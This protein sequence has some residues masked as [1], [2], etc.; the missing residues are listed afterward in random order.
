MSHSLANPKFRVAI[1]GAG[2]GGLALAVTI[3]KFAGHDIHIDLYEAHDAITTVGAGIVVSSR[4]SEVM[5]ELDMYEEISRV[6]T[7]PPSSTHGPKFRRSNIPQGGFEWFQQT[8]TPT[9]S[10]MHRQHLVDALKQYLPPSCNIHFNKRLTQYNKQL[11]GSLILHFAD[12]STSTTDVLV[13]A[14]GVHSSVRKTLFETL[15]RDVVDPSNI[16]HYTDPS[17]TGTLVYRTVFPAK[18]LS[19]LDPN[20]VALKDF[21]I[22]CGHRKQ[23]VSYPV[24][25]GTLINVVASITDEEKAGTPFEGRWVSSVSHEEVQELYQD[26]EPT[27]KNLLKCFENSSRWALHVVNELPLSVYNRV[28]LIGDACHA[29]T[30]HFGAGAGQAME[31]AFVL[32]RLLAHPLTTLDNVPAALKAYQDVRLP[33]AQFV[34]RESARTGRML[35][36][37]M[38][39]T[40]GRNVREELEIQ[41]EKLLAQWEW[42]GKDSPIAEWLEAERKLQG[43]IGV[44]KGLST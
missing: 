31:D 36:F 16:R 13:G 19:D 34:A 9:T 6:S 18:K 35:S 37:D 38:S 7:K 22:F 11:S 42:E 25:Q 14:D 12:D 4:T 2:I 27:V 15:D 23:V 43:S 26:F 32:G 29:M 10:N 40:A 24:S 44:S 21:V 5:K 30:P 33:F 17:W 41:K 8:R 39:D 3:G 28:A 1:C 20:N